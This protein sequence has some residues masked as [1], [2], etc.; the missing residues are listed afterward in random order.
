MSRVVAALDVLKRRRIAR[1]AELA[2]R[3]VERAREIEVDVQHIPT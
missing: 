3:L 1:V 2:D